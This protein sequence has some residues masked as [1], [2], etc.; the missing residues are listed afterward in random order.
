[1]I[2]DAPVV[3]ADPSQESLWRPQND[4]RKFYGPTRVRVG[5]I[6]SRNLVSIRLLETIGIPYALDYVTRFGFAPDRLPHSLSLALGAA[7]VTPLEMSKGYAAFA[8]GGY[9]VTPF[10]IDK[11][12]NSVG[13]EIFKAKPKIACESCNSTNPPK[14]D[15]IPQLAPRILSAQNAYLMT[16]AMKDVIKKGTGRRALVLKRSDLAGKTGTTNNQVD[17][18]FAGFNSDLVTIAWVGFDQPK[19]LHEYGSQAALPMWIDF[20]KVALAGTPLHTMPEPPDIVSVRINKLTGMPADAGQNDTMFELFRK[21]FVPQRGMTN[22]STPVSP[23][24]SN[25]NASHSNNPTLAQSSVTTPQE[26]TE[27]LF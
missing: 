26:T 19:S 3:F 18:W 20:M 23:Y 10:F 17:A 14:P 22:D 5:L 15:M 9:Q 8:N 21:Q 24:D 7:D 11:I 16:S 13:Q 12:D 6:K 2:N 4:T 25:N 27:Q 1:M